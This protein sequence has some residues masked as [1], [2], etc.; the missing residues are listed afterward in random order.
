MITLTEMKALSHR[1]IKDVINMPRVKGTQSSLEG[2][3]RERDKSHCS[4]RISEKM[5]NK[6]KLVEKPKMY[7]T[8]NEC[9]I[10]TPVIIIGKNEITIY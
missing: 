3:N 2:G 10:S 6:V 5:A 7:S 4:F 8:L 9:I 1:N